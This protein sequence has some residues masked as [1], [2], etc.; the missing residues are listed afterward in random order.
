[1]FKTYIKLTN[2]K[3]YVYNN[4]QIARVM[5][6]ALLNE[7]LEANLTDTK[8]SPDASTYVILSYFKTAV[9]TFYT[10]SKG[11]SIL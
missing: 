9:T 6:N 7:V 2:F 4:V 11:K 5:G 3:A 8:I 10:E 1:M